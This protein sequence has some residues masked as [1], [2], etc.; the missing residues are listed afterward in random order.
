MTGVFDVKEHNKRWFLA[1]HKEL[2]EL[3]KN[4]IEI[5]EKEI[6]Q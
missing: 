3:N 2:L 6:K 1:R 5:I 4:L